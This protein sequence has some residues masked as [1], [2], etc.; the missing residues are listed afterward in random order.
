MKKI[1]QGFTLIELMI[2]VAI[3]GILAVIAIPQYQTYVARSQV[4]RAVSESGALKTAI[5][6]CAN[7]GILTIGKAS[8]NKCDTLAIGSSILTGGSQ[9]DLSLPTGTGV[10]QAS[11]DSAGV[12]TIVAT[13]GNQAIRLINGRKI[14]WTR[15][16]DGTWQCESDADPKYNTLGCPKP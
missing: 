7:E 10:P 1:S 12:S 3:I 8:E 15:S 13:F 2:V 9:G 16:T 4:A 11:F 14:T 5:E 6:N